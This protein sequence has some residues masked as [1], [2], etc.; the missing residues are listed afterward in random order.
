MWL[1]TSVSRQT[2]WYGWLPAQE[3]HEGHHLEAFYSRSLL[4]HKP[5]SGGGSHT[6]CGWRVRSPTENTAAVFSQ[7]TESSYQGERWT[8]RQTTSVTFLPPPFL[9]PFK[10]MSMITNRNWTELARYGSLENWREVLAALVTYA[11]PDEFAPLC[12]E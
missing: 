1:W 9:F 4:F 3:L 11:G 7:E 5:L 10:L 8:T 12:G 6:C 2:E